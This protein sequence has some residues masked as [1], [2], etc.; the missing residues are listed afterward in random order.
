MRDLMAVISSWGRPLPEV[1]RAAISTETE[2]WSGQWGEL[3][4]DMTAERPLTPHEFDVA[5]AY[6]ARQWAIEHPECE[7]RYIEAST[8]S[9][10]HLRMQFIIHSPGPFPWAAVG[11]AL[12]AMFTLVCKHIIAIAVAV[13]VFMIGWALAQRL[14]PT[15]KHFTCYIC[16]VTCFERWEDLKAHIEYAHPSAPVPPKPSWG[17]GDVLKVGLIVVLAAVAFR[18]VWPVLKRK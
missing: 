17:L 15:Q 8:G 12:A 3:H 14:G 16:G 6:F 11:A 10:Q 4:G 9:P 1:V 7:L 18:F 13:A 5:F 2:A